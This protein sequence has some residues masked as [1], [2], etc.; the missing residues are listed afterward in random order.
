MGEKTLLAIIKKSGWKG[1][2]EEQLRGLSSK[3]NLLED[4]GRYRR[5][6]G[7]LETSNDKGNFTACVLEATIAFQFE[8][9]GIELDYEVRQDPDGT[10]SID[11]RWKTASGRAVYIEVCLLQQDKATTDSIGGQ[12]QNGDVYGIIG[13]GDSEKQ[14]IIRVQHAILEKVQKRD[15]TPTKFLAIHKD[16]INIVA[17]DISEIILGMFDSHDCKLVT[18]GDPSVQAVYRREVFGL[19]QESMP[20]YPEYIQSLARSYDRVGKTLHGVLFLFRQPKGELFNYSVER[21]LAWNPNLISEENATAI[22][23]EIEPALPLV[24]E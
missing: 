19:F 14:D 2:W 12:L 5:L 7:N 6:V 13:D 9:R 18:L 20:A 4:T 17:V 23:N 11:F 8:S 21:Y 24:K 22:C 3:L 15:G 1:A 16:A 10:G